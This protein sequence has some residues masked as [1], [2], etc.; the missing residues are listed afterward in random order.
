MTH[1]ESTDINKSAPEGQEPEHSERA[2][3]RLGEKPA[4]VEMGEIR[5]APPIIGKKK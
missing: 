2:S 5:A 3:L 1:M 4:N